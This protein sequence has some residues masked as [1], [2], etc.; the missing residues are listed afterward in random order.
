[1]TLELIHIYILSKISNS[2]IFT[3][4][5]SKIVN[6]KPSG[7]CATDADCDCLDCEFLCS[8]SCC[9]SCTTYCDVDYDA[10]PGDDTFCRCGCSFWNPNITTTEPS[11]VV[12]TSDNGDSHSRIPVLS[13]SL[14]IINIIVFIVS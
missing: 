8:P 7:R 9:C 3:N 10:G 14:F 11:A 5:S 2:I 1:M 13:L 4:N 6:K 12:T